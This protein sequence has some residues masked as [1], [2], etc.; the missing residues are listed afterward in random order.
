MLI[1]A[2]IRSR[3][4]MRSQLIDARVMHPNDTIAI[5]GIGGLFPGADTLEQF[6]ANVAMGSTPRATF[7]RDGG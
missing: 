7:R 4:K 3:L 2:V 1:V 6:W 5:V